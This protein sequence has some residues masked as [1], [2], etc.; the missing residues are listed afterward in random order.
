MNRKLVVALSIIGL[1]FSGYSYGQSEPQGKVIDEVVAVVGKNIILE[2]EIQNQYMQARMNSDISGTESKVKCQIL[3]NILF[4][5][6]L[7][8]QAELDSLTVND[9]QVDAIVQERIRKYFIPSFGSQEK[10]EEFYGKK[11]DEIKDEVRKSV[12]KQQLSEMV[13]QS[14][15]SSIVITPSE[16]LKFYKSLPKD[17][18]PLIN[19]EYRIA[20]IIKKPPISIEEKLAIKDRLNGFRKRIEGGEKFSTLARLYSEDPGSAKK[21]GELGFYGRGEL[22]PE[23]EATAF[24][25]KDGEM[26]DIVETKAGFHLIQMI[27]RRGDNINVRHILLRTKV[28]PMA[29]YK[30]K[31]S[32][33]SLATAIRNDSIT[34]DE[35]VK[36]FS[37]DPGKSNGGYIINKMTGGDKFSPEQLD[38][39]VLYSVNKLNVGDITN[40]VPFQDEEGRDAYRILCLKSKSLPHRADVSEDYDKISQ[41]A[42][43]MKKQEEIRRWIT[44]KI[45]TT[46]I[47]IDEEYKGCS[48]DNKWF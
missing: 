33:D 17:S 46:Y 34:F 47:K 29:L 1:L 43:G 4:Q 23:F 30:A 15:V 12:K 35:A 36:E 31:N 24:K 14:I 38:S 13:Q 21:G 39:R 25:L 26:S 41:M 40:A 9:V 11:I 27:E 3:E 42:L 10:L 37:D 28:S 8:D 22:Y 6:L 2:S 18:I 32:L 5:N 20:Q 45:K 48:F 19:S 7:L 16:V 44:E